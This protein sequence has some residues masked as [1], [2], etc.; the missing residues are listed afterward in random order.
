MIVISVCQ[1]MCYVQLMKI[2]KYI[3][4]VF[5]IISSKNT[6]PRCNMEGHSQEHADGKVRHLQCFPYPVSAAVCEVQL[7][8]LRAEVD[9]GFLAHHLGVD[10]L[11]WLDAHHQLVALALR[12]EDV[13]RHVRELQPHLRL[14]LV[15]RLATAQHEWHACGHKRD[16]ADKKELA[17]GTN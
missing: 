11:V 7:G 14:A 15:Q 3:L 5:R 6:Q 9:A 13:A 4:Y 2:M 17:T 10:G 1:Y 8:L 16:Y 12:V